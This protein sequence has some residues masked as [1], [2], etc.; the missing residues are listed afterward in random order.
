MKRKR[1]LND[2]DLASVG[3]FKAITTQGKV[4]PVLNKQE[5]KE[6]VQTK[7]EDG[8]SK[9]DHLTLFRATEKKT[10]PP[11]EIA[12][13]TVQGPNW[14]PPSSV[15]F[16]LGGVS[17]DNR[18]WLASPTTYDA[19]GIRQQGGKPAIYAREIMSPVLAGYTPRLPKP[20]EKYGET[21]RKPEIV[22]TPPSSPRRK[23]ISS[24]QIQ[25]IMNVE[26]NWAGLPL[27]KAYLTSLPKLAP[28]DLKKRNVDLND[29]TPKLLEEID[30]KSYDKEL[31]DIVFTPKVLRLIKRGKLDLETIKDVYCKFIQNDDEKISAKLL[32]DLL[33][34]YYS[35]PEELF[36]QQEM[37]IRKIIEIF[38]K[39]P[40]LFKALASCILS[41]HKDVDCSELIKIYCQNPKLFCSIMNDSK[42]TIKQLDLGQF[43]ERLKQAQSENEC[44]ELAPDDSQNLYDILHSII[45]YGMNDSF[46]QF[47]QAKDDSFKK[48]KQDCLSNVPSKYSER[49]ERKLESKC[50]EIF[51]KAF[52]QYLDEHIGEFLEIF[53]QALS[54]QPP[55]LYDD[56]I[57]G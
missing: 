57:Y 51:K 52:H 15:G 34:K 48:L 39:A 4:K 30:I 55:S 20:I 2:E 23:E 22:L 43:V 13:H 3:K 6:L 45:E 38:S 11:K 18:F 14:T 7:F 41:E 44:S 36:P 26:Y 25:K 32:C 53:D 12:E 10:L 28:L 16:V 27:N 29:F 24:E 8:K 37:S 21:D 35:K 54:D 33:T 50:Y 56:Y 46:Q 47:R 19:D 17:V 42:E 9:D 5:H 31:V 40:E 49:L 1:E